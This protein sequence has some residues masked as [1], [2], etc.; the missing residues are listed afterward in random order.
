LKLFT[1][2]LIAHCRI[3]VSLSFSLLSGSLKCRLLSASKLNGNKSAGGDLSC[4][5][6]SSKRCLRAIMT[7]GGAFGGSVV[8]SDAPRGRAGGPPAAVRQGGFVRK[9]R[10][11]ATVVLSSSG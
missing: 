2:Q 11:S 3:R 8:S 10:A 7:P 4:C 5:D 9:P 6:T 1:S